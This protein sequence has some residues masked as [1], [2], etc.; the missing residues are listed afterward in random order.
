MGITDAVTPDNVATI[1]AARLHQTR[2]FA[3]NFPSVFLALPGRSQAQKVF[4]GTSRGHDDAPVTRRSGYRK[5]GRWWLK[6][7]VPHIPVHPAHRKSLRRYPSGAVSCPV[8]RQ[9]LRHARSA[10]SHLFGAGERVINGLHQAC[11][12]L[13]SAARPPRLSSLRVSVVE[14]RKLRVFASL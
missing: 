8:K 7:L 6:M 14:H 2:C 5:P 11:D 12:C 3:A 10:R 13:S 1:C 9:L 4:R